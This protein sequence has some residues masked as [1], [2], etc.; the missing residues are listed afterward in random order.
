MTPLD[1][2]L[3]ASSKRKIN[4]GQAYDHLMPKANGKDQ[5]LNKDANVKD[6]VGKM[7]WI[8]G[9]TLSDTE[10]LAP[11]LKGRTVKESC[12]NIWTFLYNNIQY[13]LDEK[14]IEQLRRP[15]RAWR[16]RKEGIDCD[17]FSIFASSLLCNMGINNTLRITRYQG[18]WQH[19]YVIVPSEE[20]RKGYYI[21]DPVVDRFNYE[22]P[23]SGKMDF[24]IKKMAQMNGIPLSYL[25]GF[26]SISDE[27]MGILSGSDFQHIE[28]MEGLGETPSEQ[29]MLNALYN[30]ILKTRN[31]LRQNPGAFQ[32]VTDPEAYLKMLDYA[33]EYWNT[34]K[35]DAALSILEDQEKRMLSMQSM[36]GF[37]GE[38]GG[39]WDKVKNAVSSAKNFVVRNIK[40]AAKDVATVAK[41]VVRAVVRFNPVTMLARKG[42]LEIMKSN[43][44]GIA[45]NLK[46]AYATQE[47]AA[48][49]GVSADRWQRA[50]GAIAKI[51]SVFGFNTSA[52]AA[53]LKDAIV[54]GRAGG[55]S[56]LGILPLLA[57]GPIA[58]LLT[59]LLSAFGLGPKE[60]ANAVEAQPTAMEPTAD[61]QSSLVPSSGGQSF[62]PYNYLPSTSTPT[63]QVPF[64]PTRSNAASQSSIMEWIKAN[65]GKT[66]IGAVVVGTTLAL[67][68]SKGMRK[69]VGLG[70]V[71]HRKTKRKKV[72]ALHG[73]NGM[74]DLGST[75]KKKHKAKIKSIALK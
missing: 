74:G 38:L 52:S 63:S 19:V 57:A 58:E 17:C 39:F 40:S 4:D 64:G 69:G 70:A 14:G 31:Q 24:N 15:S 45:G 46:W 23:Y 32:T 73:T 54:G 22:K 67:A 43:A 68:L 55:F 66:A 42:I 18:N 44:G 75:H 26:D 53:N 48:A 20:S 72:A 51:E 8:I 61:T 16:D 3:V 25:S 37:S 33:L 71:T 29:T 21:I 28:Q 65:P 34:P 27:L 13:E 56:G 12:E 60:N 6:T 1:L 10:K 49:K 41:N 7:V 9:A 2:G 50:R 30:H 59:K 62:A 5:L 47:Q 35:R 36:Q 11:R